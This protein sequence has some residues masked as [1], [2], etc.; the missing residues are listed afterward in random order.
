MSQFFK[1]SNGSIWIYFVFSMMIIL[2]YQVETP[3]DFLVCQVSNL[4]SLFKNK[5]LNRVLIFNR[6]K[7][8][9]KCRHKGN[10]YFLKDTYTVDSQFCTHHL[11]KENDLN[12]HL[13]TS[14]IMIA[15]HTL[16]CSCI[17]CIILSLHYMH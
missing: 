13:C 6:V 12:D 16:I 5:I 4:T 7:Y 3:I 10:T 2:Y 11:I 9:A 14:K 15:L 1:N 8:D 17:T